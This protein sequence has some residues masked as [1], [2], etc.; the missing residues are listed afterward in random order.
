[1]SR[2]ICG[3]YYYLPAVRQRQYLPQVRLDAHTTILSTVSRTVLKQKFINASKDDLEEI[4]YAF[5]LFDSVSVVEFVCR[6]GDRTIYGLVKERAEA[7]KTYEEAKERGEKAALLEQLPDAADVFTTSVSNI[8]KNSSVEVSITYIQELKHDAEVDGV[9]L[10]VPTSISPRYGSYPGKLMEQ[11]AVDDA[12]GISLKIDVCMTEGIPIQ[13]VMSPSHPIEVSLGR[14]STSTS[15]EVLSLSKA[16]ASLAL[17]TAQLEKDFV[18]QVVAKDA[19]IPQAILET[20]PT[21]P[22]QRSVMTTLVPKFNLKSQKPEI[23]FIVDRS[24]SMSGNISTVIS[25]LKVFLKSIPVGCMFNICSFGSN[26]S[27]LW[28][29]SQLY[30]QDTLAEAIKHVSGFSADFGGTETLRA[31]E[32]CFKARLTEMQTELMLLTDG[33][34]WYQQQIF[35]YINAQTKSGNARVFPIGIGGGVSSALIEGIARA[36]RGFAQMVGNNEKLDSKIVRMLKG[37]LTPHI[38]DYRLELKYDDNSVDSVTD[39]L[40]VN[41]RFDDETTNEA[42]AKPISLYDTDAVEEHPKANEST[43]IFAG[44]PKLD[45]PKI[46]QAPHEIPPLFPFNRTCV[47]LLLSPSAAGATPKSVVLKGT[48]PQGPLALEIPVEIR[49]APD[50]MIHQL[51]A[52]KA[53]Q[54]LEEG[55]GWL[56][57]ATKE[58]EKPGE[59]TPIGERYPA[60][61]ALL[62]QREAVRLGVEFQVG[63]KYCSFVAVEANEA[64]IA[65]KR[66]QAID[67]CMSSGSDKEADDWDLVDDTSDGLESG[68]PTKEGMR[69]PLPTP[70]GLAQ[71]HGIVHASAGRPGLRLAESK[72]RDMSSYYGDAKRVMSPERRARKAERSRIMA[73]AMSAPIGLREPPSISAAHTMPPSQRARVVKDLFG[74]TT[75]PEAVESKL[76]SGSNKSYKGAEAEE[77]EEEDDQDEDMG[78]DLFDGG[79][80]P[81]SVGGGSGG[82][83]FLKSTASS[84][85]GNH[86]ANRFIGGNVSSSKTK[87]NDSSFG[88]EDEIDIVDKGTLLETIVAEQSFEG[89]WASIS[90]SLRKKMGINSGVYSKG[91]DNLVTS[92]YSLDR[93]LAEAALSTAIVVVYLREKLADEEETWELIVE[94]AESWLMD[95]LDEGTWKAA[96]AT[97]TGIVKA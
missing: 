56:T 65:K 80:P 83:R 88:N 29:S 1:M 46:L 52:R 26:H 42:T 34:I 93:G 4:R 40:H 79:T 85:S 30:T 62:Q 27:F 95:R 9:R 74:S 54:E 87:D 10:T 72:T 41:L 47:Y 68:Y 37:A 23:I 89:S 36:G 64:E 73:A 69:I 19:G 57:E 81:P 63:S 76:P 97:A 16:S 38:K 20:H 60:K 82:A 6:V 58:G 43:D 17:N 7:R 53:I 33:D 24:G 21:L 14:L 11:S 92:E 75:Q 71:A 84:D 78:F 32:A 44:L 86:T 94:K 39:S 77:E 31:V 13:K 5:P 25:A 3:C 8:S 91:V 55:R 61:T 48:S 66:Q 12:E 28:P 50:Q 18:L 35:S 96:W 49:T 70:A 15:D 51:A 67:R 45:R 2:H 90:M 59:M 22:N